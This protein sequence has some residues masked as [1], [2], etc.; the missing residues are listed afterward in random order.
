[1]DTDGGKYAK[2]LE[3]AAKSHAIAVKNNDVPGMVFDAGLKGNLLL[4]SGKPDL[5]KAEFEAS[6][7]LVEG[8]NLSQEIKDNAKLVHH[9]TIARVNVAK[10]DFAGA[11]KEEDAFR[12]GAYSSKNPFQQKLPHELDS[13]YTLTE[14]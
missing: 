11:K 5:A 12:Q 6:V 10:K 14:N 13:I 7:K 4:E 9:Y 2:A 3:N 1:I 8:S